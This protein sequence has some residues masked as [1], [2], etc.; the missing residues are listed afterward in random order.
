MA[1]DW[2]LLE[3]LCQLFRIRPLSS[4]LY[5]GFYRKYNGKVGERKGYKGSAVGTLVTLALTN[6]SIVSTIE[7]PLE[8][9]ITSNTISTSRL[10]Y[11]YNTKSSFH[12]GS[13]VFRT[14]VLKVCSASFNVTKG[15]SFEE[16]S[17]L[18]KFFPLITLRRSFPIAG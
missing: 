3:I 18:D 15:F 9:P 8:S 4:M 10:C 6:F 12:S 11:T 7:S 5:W 17:A 14:F 13:L 2:I 1:K 16:S